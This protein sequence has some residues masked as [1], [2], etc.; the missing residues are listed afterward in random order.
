[1]FFFSEWVRKKS[2]ISVS[3]A[4]RCLPR[5]V[6]WHVLKRRLILSITNQL[7]GDIKWSKESSSRINHSHLFTSFYWF[8]WQEYGR[9]HALIVLLWAVLCSAE[10][11]KV[12]GDAE[13]CSFVNFERFLRQRQRFG[14]NV[15]S[16]FQLRLQNHVF[17]QQPPTDGGIAN[18]L[19]GFQF[20]QK[21]HTSL[22]FEKWVLRFKFS[23]F[24]LF[25]F[26]IWKLDIFASINT[27]F[28]LAE[29]K[30]LA[31]HVKGRSARSGFGSSSTDLSI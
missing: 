4:R 3:C 18:L 8:K 29:K 13:K 20:I 21:L 19:C 11:L 9:V 30:V 31:S 1:M 10:S 28:I 27:R 2:P 24:G 5:R 26:M 12:S 23:L 16:S 22:F 17:F 7:K 15:P 14:A 25:L 6:F